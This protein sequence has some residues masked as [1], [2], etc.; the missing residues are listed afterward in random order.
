M[1]REIRLALTEIGIDLMR[2]LNFLKHTCRIPNGEYEAQIIGLNVPSTATSSIIIYALS[3]LGAASSDE[4]DRFV[5]DLMQSHVVS[6][7]G[8]VVFTKAKPNSWTTA[9]AALALMSARPGCSSLIRD[10]LR[11]LAARFHTSD[12]AWT[13]SGSIDEHILYAVYPTIVF[14]RASNL[15]DRNFDDVLGKTYFYL[16]TATFE[17]NLER[18][19]ALSLMRKIEKVLNLVEAPNIT[20]NYRQLIELELYKYNRVE[21]TIAAFGLHIFGPALYLLSRELMPP[22]HPFA[23]Y[24]IKALVDSVN[25]DGSS[26]PTPNLTAATAGVQCTFSTALAI[27]TL[28]QWVTDCRVRGMDAARLT[29]GN[30]TLSDIK[31]EVGNFS[32]PKKIFVSYSSS[33]E[34]IAT[35]IYT[36]LKQLGYDVIYAKFDLIVGDSIPG[37]ISKALEEMDYMVLCLSPAAVASKYVKDEIEGGKAKEWET[38]KK[39]ILPAL[40]K[41]CKIP[42]LLKAKR[43][44]DFVGSFEQGLADL[45]TAIQ[46]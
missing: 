24:C 44:A 22:D 15:Y 36:K 25:P 45:L 41:D 28:T 1:N 46:R 34:A 17:S 6:T 9:Q 3:R 30:K 40:V 35:Q 4:T 29:G 14:V 5:D 13:Y 19:V 38:E 21:H 27:I 23:L 8:A 18:L 31:I 32:M 16:R 42:G 43:Y 12:G 11:G 37:F 7:D 20:I 26:W 2:V 39:V 10:C 33:D